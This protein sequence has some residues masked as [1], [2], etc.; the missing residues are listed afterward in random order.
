MMTVDEMSYEFDVLASSYLHEHG[1]GKSDST[2]LAF[3]EYEKSVYLTREQE[4][5]VLA[6]YSD[7]SSIGSFERTEQLRRDLDNLLDERVLDAWNE[8]KTHITNGTQFFRLAD[9]TDGGSYS[10]LNLWFIVY[11]AARYS[12]DGWDN[13]DC[14]ID[15]SDFPVEVVPI[16]YDTFHRIKGNPFRGP[17]RRRALRLDNGKDVSNYVEILSKYPLGKYYVKYIRRPRPIILTDL[18]DGLTINGESTKSSCELHDSLHRLILD[19]AV[20]MAI[21]SRVGPVKEEKN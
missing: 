19:G 3:N 13:T 16:T 14:P 10:N 15:E 18:G 4:N 7:S 21:S 12:T 9:L 1:F 6:L 2:M 17:N 5:L 20:R 8:D 11:E